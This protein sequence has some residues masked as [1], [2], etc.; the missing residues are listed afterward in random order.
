M[1][2][3]FCGGQVVFSLSYLKSNDS[4]LNSLESTKQIKI[5]P[6]AQFSY[7]CETWSYATYLNESIGLVERETKEDLH[8]GVKVR[9]FFFFSQQFVS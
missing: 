3:K 5:T 7:D 8:F 4:V 2:E 1:F 6:K 9:M